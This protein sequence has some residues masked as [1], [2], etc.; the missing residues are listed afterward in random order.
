VVD[1]VSNGTVSYSAKGGCCSL[2]AA[3][4]KPGYTYTFNSLKITTVAISGKTA[5]LRL[6]PA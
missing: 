6:K 5:I 2:G 1:R 4:E 3:A